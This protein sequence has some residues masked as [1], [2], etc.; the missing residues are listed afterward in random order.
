MLRTPAGVLPFYRLLGCAVRWRSRAPRPAS[1]YSASPGCF[2]RE[3]IIDSGAESER[4]RLLP[5]S[6]STVGL[7]VAK[8]ELFLQPVHSDRQRGTRLPDQTSELKTSPLKPELGETHLKAVGIGRSVTCRRELPSQLHA[9]PLLQSSQAS[10][11]CYVPLPY[12][13]MR[14]RRQRYS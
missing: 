1:N 9:R 4:G 14:F 7:V 6:K 11:S 5:A 13:H 2:H 10:L 12:L 8:R 3:R